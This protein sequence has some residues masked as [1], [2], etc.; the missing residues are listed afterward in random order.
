MA[1]ATGFASNSEERGKEKSSKKDR[2]GSVV[3]A[4][5]CNDRKV[6]FMTQERS[7]E[8]K[9]GNKLFLPTADILKLAR[10][11]AQMQRKRSPVVPVCQLDAPRLISHPPLKFSSVGPTQPNPTPSTSSYLSRR[12]RLSFLHPTEHLNL[13]YTISRMESRNLARFWRGQQAAISISSGENC[14][15]C[16]WPRM[17]T[18]AAVGRSVGRPPSPRNANHNDEGGERGER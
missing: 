18:R 15:L 1:G 4:V 7:N 2:E 12:P 14:G 5:S 13:L 16:W 6:R 8:W 3:R 10:H 9:F 17:S 11:S